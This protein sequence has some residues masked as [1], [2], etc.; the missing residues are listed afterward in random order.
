MCLPARSLALVAFGIRIAPAGGRSTPPAGPSPG[1]RG[2]PGA[3]P[4]RA[5]RAPGRSPSLPELVIEGRPDGC[6]GAEPLRGHVGQRPARVGGAA[7]VVGRR[8]AVAGQVEVEQHRV[9]VGGEQDVRRLDVAVGD[10]AA[11]GVVEGLGQPGDDPGDRP[12]VGQPREDLAGRP[13]IVRA[14]ILRRRDAVEV[15]Q[16]VAAGGRRVGPLPRRTSRTAARVAP[17]KNGMQINWNAPSS[18]RLCR[19]ISTMWACRARASSHGSR[20][21]R[22]E[23]LTTTRRFSRSACSARKTRAKP[24]R[25][26]SRRRR[27][28]PIESPACGRSASADVGREPSAQQ[29]RR[30]RAVH[31]QQPLQGL[32]MLREAGEIRRRVRGPAVR[33]R[34]G[35]IPGRSARR[36]P[37]NRPGPGGAGSPR[38]TGARRAPR[39]R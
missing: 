13:P 32:A 31:V 20:V 6:Q 1:H 35:R 29:R 7:R 22:V 10:L 34:P 16:Q 39:P 2:R 14:R 5:S 25:P 28:G 4:D 17:P 38:P 24:P 12:V 36:P 19:T 18:T 21:T 26:S 9:A 15:R 27:Y 33:P 37:R 11:E 8:G 23:T 30:A 3:A